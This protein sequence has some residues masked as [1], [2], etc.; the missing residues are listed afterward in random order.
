MTAS[1]VNNLTTDTEEGPEVFVDF[2]S[3]FFSQ[4]LQSSQQLDISSV[5]SFTSSDP[6]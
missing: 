6:T 5:M 3:Q 4:W 1:T 2:C